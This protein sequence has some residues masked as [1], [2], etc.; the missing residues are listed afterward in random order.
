MSDGKLHLDL[1]AR[2]DDFGKK[3]YIAK[4]KGPFTIDC[5]QGACFICFVSDEG[6]EELQICHLTGPKK[7]REDR[8]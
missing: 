8:R 1:E 6:N 4:L 2:I 5:Q 3:Y 7:D